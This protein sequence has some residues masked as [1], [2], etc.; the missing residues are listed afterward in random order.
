[1]KKKTNKIKSDAP[2]MTSYNNNGSRPFVLLD[3]VGGN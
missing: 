2:T 1:V 3:D